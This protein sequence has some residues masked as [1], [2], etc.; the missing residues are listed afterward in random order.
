M[1]A[2]V[3]GYFAGW[4]YSVAFVSVCSLYANI[5]SDF[6]AYRADDNREILERLERIERLVHIGSKGGD[7]EVDN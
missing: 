4:I 3:I 5:A 1:I 7:T 2:T 6:A